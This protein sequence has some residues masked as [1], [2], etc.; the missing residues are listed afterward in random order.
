MKSIS[1][2]LRAFASLSSWAMILLGLALFAMRIPFSPDGFI[3][4]P[5]A[6]TVLQTGGLMFAVFGLQMMAS[7]AVWPSIHLDE[8]LSK[9][10]EGQTAPAYVI[11]GLLVF[12]GLSIVGFSYWLTTALGAGIGAR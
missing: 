8:L 6:F 3:N 4:L 2:R 1:L 9:V 7:M 12:N 5:M 10:A 11:L